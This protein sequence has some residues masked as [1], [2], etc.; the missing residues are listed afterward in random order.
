MNE[1][2][3]YQMCCVQNAVST[4]F[5]LNEPIKNENNFSVVFFL[6]VFS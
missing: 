4:M 3:I 2:N 1:G 5:F 6:R